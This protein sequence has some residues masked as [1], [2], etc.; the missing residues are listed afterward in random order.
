MVLEK[1]KGIF[2]KESEYKT[3]ILDGNEFIT[4]F[5]EKIRK[6]R[7]KN[8]KMFLLEIDPNKYNKIDYPWKI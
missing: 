6:K 7:A 1:L 4:I 3:K 5:W 8:L 2:S